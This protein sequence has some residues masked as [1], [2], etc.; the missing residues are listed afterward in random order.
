[1]LELNIRKTESFWPSCDDN[2][3]HG[4]IFPLDIDGKMLGMKL[5]GGDFSRDRDFIEGLFMKKV[6]RVVKLMH[7]LP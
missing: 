7:L 2:K 6:G 3:F 1:M 5:L 4:V